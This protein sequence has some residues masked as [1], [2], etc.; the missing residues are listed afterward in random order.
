MEKSGGLPWQG[1]SPTLCDVTPAARRGRALGQAVRGRRAGVPR[2]PGGGP[3]L[4]SAEDKA[5]VCPIVSSGSYFLL[6]ILAFVNQ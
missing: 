1:G 6:F 3:V 2:R 4:A 5:S